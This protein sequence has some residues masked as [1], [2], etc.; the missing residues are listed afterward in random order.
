MA[1]TEIPNRWSEIAD[2]LQPSGRAFIDGERVD[3]RD[4]R[5]FDSPVDGRVLA[6]VAEGDTTGLRPAKIIDGKTIDS[7]PVSLSDGRLVSAAQL[8]RRFH[9]TTAG[10]ALVQTGAARAEPNQRAEL[11]LSSCR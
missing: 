3:A 1:T 11:S 4:G 7:S 5:T 6:T 9:N 10:T 8:I 2:R